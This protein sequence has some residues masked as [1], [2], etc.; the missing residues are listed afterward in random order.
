MDNL[1]R[2]SDYDLFA[3]VATGLAA[4]VI[5]DLGTGTHWVVG[6]DWTV[7]SGTATIIVSYV[8]GH[9]LAWPASWLIE[10]CFVSN[11]L[12]PPSKVLFAAAPKTPSVAGWL[13]PDY[14]NPL[15][16]QMKVRVRARA[17]EDGQSAQAG[18]S[19]FWT[20]FARAKRD[21]T[22]YS[23]M[24]GFLKLYG[25]CRNVAFV[26]LA[27]CVGL[28]IAAGWS[29]WVNGVVADARSQLRWAGAA[30]VVGLSLFY[31]YLKFHRLYSVEVF[32][33][34]AELPAPKGGSDIA[35]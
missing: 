1:L 4:I 15:D 26:G 8:L 18:E 5:W 9:I 33:G 28:L 24:E 10:R 25:F 14:F 6:A 34:Y 29:L 22:T 13:F 17:R 23:R 11:V 30:F 2:F 3:Y 21:G 31:R 20:A 19:L 32:V 27:G 7:A 35:Y 16:D 12:G